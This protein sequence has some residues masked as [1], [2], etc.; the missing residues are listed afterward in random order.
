MFEDETKET[1]PAKKRQKSETENKPILI[2]LSSGEQEEDCDEGPAKLEKE[3]EQEE[4]Q[5][6]NIV[7]KDLEGSVRPEP[8]KVRDD[9]FSKLIF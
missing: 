1:E 3:I 2:A 4:Q 6:D 9:F 8:N 5:A 7:I